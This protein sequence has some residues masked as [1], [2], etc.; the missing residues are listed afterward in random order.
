MI[1]RDVDCGREVSERR[2]GCGYDGEARVATV[3]AMVVATVI[4][5]TVKLLLEDKISTRVGE[6]PWRRKVNAEGREIAG[7][8]SL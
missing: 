5:A 4:T 1:V 6:R 3:V 7:T 2:K 8:A